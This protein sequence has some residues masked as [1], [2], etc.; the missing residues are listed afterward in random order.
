MASKIGFLS[1]RVGNGKGALVYLYK[2]ER[3]GG[4]PVP[5]TVALMHYC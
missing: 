3:R 2:S 4:S 1:G 5:S